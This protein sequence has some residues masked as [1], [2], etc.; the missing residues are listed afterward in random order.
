VTTKV[1]MAGVKCVPIHKFKD[2]HHHLQVYWE[3]LQNHWETVQ[4]IG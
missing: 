2:K 3:C 4:S 1:G